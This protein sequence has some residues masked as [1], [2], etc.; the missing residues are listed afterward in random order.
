MPGVS[1]CLTRAVEPAQAELLEEVCAGTL[2]SS[3]E[4]SLAVA[5]QA[6]DKPKPTGSKP[7][8]PGLFD[9]IEA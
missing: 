3:N 2:I 8:A 4:L 5:L 6:P 1:K 7:A 9:G